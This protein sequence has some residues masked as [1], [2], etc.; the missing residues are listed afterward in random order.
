MTG[1]VFADLVVEFTEELEQPDSEEVV[2]F[3]KG[4]MINII[5]SRQ[6]WELFVD[7]VAN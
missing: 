4:I 5:S 6:T 1:Q 2:M 7:E 3:E